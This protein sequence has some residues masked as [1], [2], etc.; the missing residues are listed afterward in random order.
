MEKYVHFLK[1][2]EFCFYC[3]CTEISLS[4]GVILVHLLW[5]VFLVTF[6]FMARADRY[7][8]LTQCFSSIVCDKNDR[9]TISFSLT[10]AAGLPLALLE[11]VISN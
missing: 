1:S 8:F 9:L 7:E 2:S 4:H 11:L 6:R 3:K 10:S 5:T